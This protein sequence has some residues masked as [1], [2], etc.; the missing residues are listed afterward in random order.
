MRN[1]FNS[2]VIISSLGYFVDI[3]DL[4]LFSIVRIPSLKAIGV[5]ANELMSRGVTLLNM[6][7]GG[8]LLGGILW[9]I[10]GDKKGRVSVLYGSILLYSLANLANA[11]V[12]SFEAYAVLRFISGLGLAGELGAAVTL[13][14]ERMPVASRGYGVALVASIGILGA[15]CAAFVSNVFSWQVAYIV[16]GVMGLLLLVFRMK[17]Q[18]SA[19]FQS[20]HQ[21]SSIKK[22]SFFM[23]FTNRARFFRYLSC[24]FI[25]APN[26]FIIGILVAF[27]PEITAQRAVLEPVIVGHGIGWLYFGLSLGDLGSG[28]LSQWLKSRKKIVFLFL[29]M[30]IPLIVVYLT[31]TNAH[32]IMYYALFFALGICNGYWAVFVTIAAEQ[33]GTNLRATATTTIPNFVRG[34]VI[35]LT[36]SVQALQGR[37]GLVNAVA[38]VGS[39][40]F[41][42]AYTAL[43]FLE[44][45]YHKD[46]NFLETS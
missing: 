4:I 46:L 26:W 39:I 8:M 36:L 30:S 16:G 10:L 15:I 7:M 32:A 13:V 12:T 44:E 31:T 23:F 33:F 6:Q 41:V 35:P 14:T 9:G 45:T 28:F 27:A 43:Y 38:I 20:V 1:L 21:D 29:A 37:I 22:G 11:F 3:Y 19:L 34:M 17:M 18:D 42:L 24:I 25:G 2:T 40:C 5:P